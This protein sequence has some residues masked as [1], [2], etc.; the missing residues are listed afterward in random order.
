[1]R[2]KLGGKGTLILAFLFVAIAISVDLTSTKGL[3]DNA[4]WVMVVV[5]LLAV[6][7]RIISTSVSHQGPEVNLPMHLPSKDSE[8]DPQVKK[9][10]ESLVQSQAT[11]GQALQYIVKAVQNST[12][13]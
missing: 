12:N 6:L 11:N 3:S 4:T 7:P 5:Y 2:Y 10:L 8:P 1:M 9:A 13:E